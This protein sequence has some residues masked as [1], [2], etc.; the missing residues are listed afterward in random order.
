MDD[1]IDRRGGGE[2]TII[3]TRGT[4]D[5]SRAVAVPQPETVAGKVWCV[6]ELGADYIEEME[7]VFG[8][9]R[10]AVLPEGIGGLPGRSG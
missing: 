1:A 10:A 5:D 3:A 4:R 8:A 9:L 2:A 7:D 6:A